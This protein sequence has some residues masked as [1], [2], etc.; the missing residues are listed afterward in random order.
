MGNRRIS[1]FRELTK[2]RSAK[3]RNQ[4]CLT[5]KPVPFR[6]NPGNVGV[7]QPKFRGYKEE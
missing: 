7:I 5:P 1:N 3:I 2:S 6:Q 4:I